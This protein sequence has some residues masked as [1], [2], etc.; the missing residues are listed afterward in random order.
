MVLKIKIESYLFY[1]TD[2]NNWC[3][4]N[5]SDESIQII[6]EPEFENKAHISPSNWFKLYFEKDK[7]NYVIENREIWKQQH[8]EKYKI[9]ITTAIAHEIFHYSFQFRNGLRPPL[10]ILK[11]PGGFDYQA[12]GCKKQ[13]TKNLFCINDKETSRLYFK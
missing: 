8:K 9:D 7:I 3:K 6:R 10:R 4:H 13:R 11:K 12:K 5:L 1:K 2:K